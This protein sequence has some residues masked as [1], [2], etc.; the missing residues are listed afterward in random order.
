[1]LAGLEVF[2]PWVVAIVVLYLVVKFFS[3][4]FSFVWNGIVG[5]IMLWVVNLVG[6]GFGFHMPI[7]IISALIAGFFGIPGVVV[8][9]I[10][11]LISK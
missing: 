10:Y 2:I 5:G 3:L 4:S 7:N 9:I 11:Q 8:L 6:G 1:M